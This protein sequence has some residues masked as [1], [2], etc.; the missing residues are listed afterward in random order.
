VERP[1]V[2]A[3]ERGARLVRAYATVTALA[4]VAIATFLL[5]DGLPAGPD[6]TSLVVIAVV[7]AAVPPVVLWLFSEALRA[8]AALPGRV[9]SLPAE[10]RGRREELRRLAEAAHGAR[11]AR[12]VTFPL[13]IWRLGRAANSSRELLRPYAGALPLLSPQFLVLSGLATAAAALEIGVAA[14]LILLLLA[15]A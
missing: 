12:L 14:V 2:V 4:A 10:G 6:E 8:L 1:L 5:R 11:G 7:L 13:L 3:A 15:A 9:R